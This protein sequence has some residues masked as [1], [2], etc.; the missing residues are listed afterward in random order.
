[1]TFLNTR[2]PLAALSTLTL[3]A[4]L[5]AGA[6][7]LAQTSSDLSVKVNVADLHSGSGQAATQRQLRA[8]ADHFCR[9]NPTEGRTVYEC[10]VAM[11][12]EL[13]RNLAARTGVALGDPGA[14]RLAS[15]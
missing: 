15:K 3:A 14:V 6:P 8:A 2:S 4:A 11:T 5:L 13:E 7:A 10:R 12:S 9:A 1:M